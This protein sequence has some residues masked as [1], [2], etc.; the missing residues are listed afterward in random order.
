MSFSTEA[1]CITEMSVLMA[2]WKQNNFVD[3]LCSNEISSFYMCVEKA[4]VRPCFCTFT[5][6]WDHFLCDQS[7]ANA[8]CNET[9]PCI[10]CDSSS[11]EELRMGM[12][13][14]VT[15]ITILE[16]FRV[17]Q[18]ENKIC[19]ICKL[20][21][22]VWFGCTTYPSGRKQLFLTDIHY[23]SNVWIHLLM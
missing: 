23:Q 9:C 16:H 21:I 17:T 11:T 4:Q 18:M 7:P 20:C 10:N 5:Q 13:K 15:S 14:S 1:S 6:A 12:E 3:T 2:C 22:L 19:I 8:E